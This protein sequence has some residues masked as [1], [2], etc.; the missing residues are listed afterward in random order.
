MINYGPSSAGTDLKFRVPKPYT[1]RSLVKL[2]A[3]VGNQILGI[4]VIPDASGQ[5]SISGVGGYTPLTITVLDPGKLIIKFV[6]ENVAAITGDNPLLI[7]SP[8]STI[9]SPF[10][11]K[12]APKDDTVEF[13]AWWDPRVKTLLTVLKTM[14]RYHHGGMLVVVPDND[15]WRDSLGGSIPYEAEEPSSALSDI[16]ARVNDIHAGGILQSEELGFTESYLDTLAEALA[17]LTSVD[18]AV[19]VTYDLKIVG[20]GAKFRGASSWLC[21]QT[22]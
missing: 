6:A 11:K 18:G 9:F 13:S 3:A 1:V 7:R 2:G 10:W 8:H 4:S 17:S 12:F 15:G 22:T 21:D 20:F 16:I 5:L 19:V 14:Q